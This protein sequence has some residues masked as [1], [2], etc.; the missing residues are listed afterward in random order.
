MG[1]AV[2]NK[3]L[4]PITP[5]AE[6]TERIL[7]LRLQTSS[8]PVSLISTYA[9]TLVSTAEAKDKF[10]DDLSTAI[11]RIPDRELLFIA[12]DF[13]ARV[14]V[15]HNSWPTCLGQFGIGKMNE[16]GQSLLEL[17]CHHGLCVSNTFFNTKPQH[18]V[19]WR[20][21]RLKHWH[22]LDLILTRRVD[23]SSIK[24][25][26][27]YQSAD[28]DTDHSLVCSKVKLRM[29]SL[30]RTRKEGRPRINISKTRD[31][32][33]V[34]EFAQ[35]LEDSLPGPSTA[36][37]QDRWKHFRDAVYNTAMPTFGK[38]TSK[39]ADWF[40]AHSE[41]MTPVIEAKRNALI[42][43][44]ANPSDQ[45][46]QILRAARSKV[47]QRARQCASDY[48]LQLYSQIQI[49]ADTGN[50]KAMYDGIKQALGPTQQ[51]TALLKSATGEVIQDRKQ[52]MERWVEHYT[53]LYA[54]ENVVIEDALNAIECLPELEELDR[55]L[56]IDELSE[57]LDS[58]ASGKAPG[59]D[60]IPVE[61]LKCCKETLITGL[62]EILCLCWSEGE[63]PQDMRDANVVTLY[64]N[65]G[66]RGDCN[67]YRG[68]SLLSV[69]GKVFARGVLKRL[70][71]LAEQV[72]PESQCGFRA[73]RSNVDMVFSLRQLQ[74]K[75]REQRQPLFVAF[76]DVTKAFN[77]VSRDGLFKI[78][79][80]IGC[81][82]KLF[83]IIRS[84]HE[85]MKVT[86]VFDGSTSAAFNIRSGVKQGCVLAPTLFEIFF[87]MML[88]HAFG[89]AAEVIYLRTRTDRKLFN[90]SRLRAKTKVQMLCMR[91]FLFADDAAVTAHSA[92]DLQQL[93]TRFSDAC[94]DF[95]LT[96]SLKK[97]Q[98]MGQDTDSSPA[99]SI[100]DHETGCHPRLRLSGLSY[101]RHPLTRR[102]DQQAHRQGHDQTDKESMEQQQADRAHKDPDLQS[103]RREHSPVWQ[104]VLDI[105]CPTGAKLN[106]F[107]M[108]SLR[109]ILNIT[110]QDKVPNNTVLERAGCTSMFTLLKQ[111]RMRWLGH[112]VRMDDGRIPNDLLCGELMQGKRPTGR[113]QLRF[114][115]VGKRD[116]KALNINQS[117][118]EA[119]ALKRS[120][121]RQT[122][123]KGLSN[124]KETLAQQHREKRMRR[125]AAAHADR[126]TSDFV[127]VL[128]H[129]DCHSRI[130]LVSHTRHCTRI[131]T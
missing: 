56:T 74:E 72:Y 53:E 97:T 26:R 131:K 32:R 82:P 21:P 12:G 93:M 35:V 28:C 75:C 118:W 11:R 124:F 110:W 62:H 24:I 71:V 115:D 5:P 9:P 46:L 69:V 6:G 78:L 20:H 101:L 70:Q 116:L 120:A 14:G 54:K 128:C 99:I 121:W 88:K 36:N 19:S 63:V 33:K 30:H 64:K 96:I 2:R 18:R 51:K 104:R 119:A 105:A 31:H 65:K 60:G 83:S 130:G 106:A 43:Y 57:A 47:Q 44:K 79:P 123:Q 50:I 90:L 67:N 80:K 16:N 126:P 61:V 22:Q 122:V 39:S 91:D 113:P 117:K 34:E 37:A 127:C 27:S 17:R 86:V 73:N 3:L 109:R 112:V 129:R 107:H 92:E 48:W 108:R 84:F 68:I 89:S 98:V 23:L 100:N 15:D 8:G 38:K 1:F 125:K 76:I 77:L 59:K 49:A 111:R 103:L 102:R 95:G 55:E 45:N 81:P 40:E 85:D 58:L 52:Q 66:D 42:A 7:S 114:K 25:T 4:G 94:Q 87:A 13:N 10:Y 41:E 29:K